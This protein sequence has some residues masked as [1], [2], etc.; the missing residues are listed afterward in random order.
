MKHLTEAEEEAKKKKIGIHSTKNPV[1]PSKYNDLGQ[2]KMAAKA[3]QFF[4]FIKNEPTI[5]GIVDAVLSGS[6]F[7]VRLEKQNCYIL[8]SLAGV[9][10]YS[11]EKNVPQYERF[12][13]EALKFSKDQVLQREVEL[14]V[15]SIGKNGV[16]QGSLYVAKKNFAINLIENGLAYV[17]AAGRGD[18]KYALQY[19]NLEKTAEEKKVGIWGAGIPVRINTGTTRGGGAIKQINES[20]VVTVSEVVST[21][22]IYVHYKEAKKQLDNVQTELA[23]PF[24]ADSKLEQPVK[25]GIPC[26]AKF[27]EDGKWYRARIEK[28]ITPSKFGVVFTDYGNYDEVSYDNLRKISPSL[29]AIEPLAKKTGLAYTES[30]GNKTGTYEDAAER[31]RELIW[32]KEITVNFVYEDG[33]TK[34]GLFFEKKSNDTKDSVNY[35]VVNEGYARLAEDIIQIPADQLGPLRDADENARLKKLGGWGAGDFVEDDDY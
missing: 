3:K 2:Q 4:E 6:L 12:A 30:A 23:K 18:Q 5:P 28:T 25:R 7:K 15:S 34:Y 29:L 35:R 32:E 10:T 16:F 1:N 9:R 22:E 33:S 14:N 8:F 20:K 31:I 21:D 27:S 26:V 17:E 24:G 13:K 19:R 11:N